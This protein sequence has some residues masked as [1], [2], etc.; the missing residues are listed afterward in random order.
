MTRL[1]SALAAALL[2]GASAHAAPTERTVHL[3]FT[4]E[5]RGTVGV[6]G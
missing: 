3:V 5:V 6:C 1:L 2:A 4:S